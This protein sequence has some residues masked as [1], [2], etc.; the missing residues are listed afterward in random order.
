M[1]WRP[2]TPSFRPGKHAQHGVADVAFGEHG[3][4]SDGTGGP[5]EGSSAMSPRARSKAK[6]LWE[7]KSTDDLFQGCFKGVKQRETA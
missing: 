7:E 4:R 3:G 5:D 2:K 1:S 6:L